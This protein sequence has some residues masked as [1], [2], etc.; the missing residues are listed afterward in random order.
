MTMTQ[1]LVCFALIA[2][3]ASACDAKLPAAPTPSPSAG[4]PPPLVQSGSGEIWNLTGTYGGHTGPA[5]CIPPFDASIVQAPI[6]G[7]IRIQRSGGSIDVITEHDHYTGTVAADA[8]VAT[9]SDTGT[10]QCGAA[11]LSFRAE[12]HVSGAFSADGRSLS[13]EEGVTFQLESGDT[14]TRRWIWAATRQ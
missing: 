10:W 2:A 13:G 1:R 12:G 4:A 5:A 9:D 14:I 11:R 6:V 7:T 3:A 8:Y